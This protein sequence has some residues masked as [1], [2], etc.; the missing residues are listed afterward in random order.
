[1]QPQQKLIIG[2]DQLFYSAVFLP[3][4]RLKAEL[5][6]NFFGGCAKKL[7]FLWAPVDLEKRG[8]YEEFMGV[9]SVF[10]IQGSC[11]SA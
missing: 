1:M 7:V 5:G 3:F 6:F 10:G 11:K 9:S 2:L 8:V 4:W